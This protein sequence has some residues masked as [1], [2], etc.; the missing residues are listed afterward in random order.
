MRGLQNSELSFNSQQE[1]NQRQAGNE[2]ILQKMP[3]TYA[4]QRG[5]IEMI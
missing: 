4:S 5:E 3:K 1:K 2:K